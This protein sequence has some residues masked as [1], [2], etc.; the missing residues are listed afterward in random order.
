MTTTTASVTQH[1]DKPLLTPAEAKAE[2]VEPLESM[3]GASAFVVGFAGDIWLVFTEQPDPADDIVFRVWNV[4]A[5]VE[6][7]PS[8]K[9]RLVNWTGEPSYSDCLRFVSDAVDLTF[10]EEPADA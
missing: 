7:L 6:T 10:S 3:E 5:S 9:V 1:P 4:P 2:G 8:A